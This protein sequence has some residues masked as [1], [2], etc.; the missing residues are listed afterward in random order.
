MPGI[1]LGYCQ[2]MIGQAMTGLIGLREI[3][4]AL[5]AERVSADAPGLGKRLVAELKKH[6]YVPGVAAPLYE[7]ALLREYGK[8]LQTR[9]S[10][11]EDHA[12][13][14]PRKEHKPWY[15]TLFA[16]KC[17]GCGECLP[18]CPNGVLGWNPE[19]TVVLVLEPYECAPGC[20]K[21]ARA[22]LP[23]AIIMPP[24]AVLY[25]RPGGSSADSPGACARCFPSVRESCAKEE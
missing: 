10:G 14:D 22:C 19:H 9:G 5:A 25:Q 21:C 24:R 1:G 16:E 2:V 20:E 13:R 11:E 12:W 6:N 18:V 17:N 15:P 8:Y 23:Q 7:A 3:M 4:E